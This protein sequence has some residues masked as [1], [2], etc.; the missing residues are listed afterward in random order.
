ASYA[1]PD[2]TAEFK[3][4]LHGHFHA[5]DPADDVKRYYTYRNRGYL[6]SQPGMRRIGML[7]VFRFG[8]YFLVTKRDPQAFRQWLQLLRQGRAE[9]FYRHSQHPAGHLPR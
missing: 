1:H 6:L 7:E 2:G 4:M 5:Q 8:L 9:R 3:P